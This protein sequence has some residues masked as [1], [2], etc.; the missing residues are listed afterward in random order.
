MSAYNEV[1]YHTLKK[2]LE[3][4]VLLKEY[5]FLE[6]FYIFNGGGHLHFCIKIKLQMLLNIIESK[7]LVYS[8]Y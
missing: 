1:I 6:I 4:H 3:N 5:S 7:I 8:Q 2:V